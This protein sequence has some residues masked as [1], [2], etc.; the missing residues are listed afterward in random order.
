MVEHS[1]FK[2]PSIP[3]S[4]NS[5]YN[6]I[7]SLKKVSLKPEVSL[8]KSKSKMFI[9]DWKWD[10]V[11]HLYFNA[12][13][14]MNSYYKNG[15]LKKHDLQNLEKC[16]IDTVFEKLGIPDENIFAK[17]TRKY[18]T[19]NEEYVVV[20]IGELTNDTAERLEQV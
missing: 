15:K 14:Y 20:T 9:P 6:I 4:V 18:H 10:G 11:S 8:W 17:L 1:V 7:F 13:I 19:D 12:D 5:L 3:P 16:L 2:I